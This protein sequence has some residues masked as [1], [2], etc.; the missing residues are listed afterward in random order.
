MS[1]PANST[2]GIALLALGP[3]A[4]VPGLGYL[5]QQIPHAQTA[6]PVFWGLSLAVGVF[7]IWLLP[8]ERLVRALLIIPYVPIMFCATLLEQFM[9]WGVKW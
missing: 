3:F 8:I 4:A 1:R 5:L 9:L 7:G 6:G 2:M